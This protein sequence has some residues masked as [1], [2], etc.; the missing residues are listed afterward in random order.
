MLQEPPS[1]ALISKSRMNISFSF[2]R[3]PYFSHWASIRK[4]LSGRLFYY[5]T[6]VSLQKINSSI[7][8]LVWNRRNFCIVDLVGILSVLSFGKRRRLKRFVSWLW[9]TDF[10]R[11]CQD[12]QLSLFTLQHLHHKRRREDVSSDVFS[13]YDPLCSKTSCQNNQ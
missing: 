9:N 6:S 4:L 2:E 1:P 3:I 5:I 8:C 13:K 10:T 7:I 11:D 12:I